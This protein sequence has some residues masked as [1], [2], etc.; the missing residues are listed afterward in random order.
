MSGDIGDNDKTQ[1]NS[2]K[3]TIILITDN[4]QQYQ[5]DFSNYNINKYKITFINWNNILNLIK[6]F[7]TTPNNKREYLELIILDISESVV[8][9][10]VAQINQIPVNLVPIIEQIKNIF[11]TKRIFFIISS[12][13]SR[14]V[15]TFL[16]KGLC[17]KREDI[18]IQ[19]FSIFDLLDL[20]S[21]T[22][23]TE[24]LERLQLKNRIV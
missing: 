19:P 14:I 8:K 9:E 12:S 23:Q 7:N 18:R 5:E 11:S 4:I 16:S 20:I 10:N 6:N 13:Q 17:N 15:D 3:K 24:R 2:N 22:N 1:N 21:I